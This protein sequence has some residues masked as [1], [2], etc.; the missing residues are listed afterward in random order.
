MGSFF[1]VYYM[2][3]K[4]CCFIVWCTSQASAQPKVPWQYAD[5]NTDGI[6]GI[7]LSQAYTLLKSKKSTTVIV[8]VIDSGIDTLQPDIAPILWK[9]PKEKPY[10][11][12]DDDGNGL[13]DDIIGWNY[14]G[15]PNMQNLAISVPEYYRTYYRFK[16]TYNPKKINKL[17]KP[18]LYQYQELK[19]AEA[20]L[21]A[22]YTEAL[23]R[24]DELLPYVTYL[25]LA[26]SSNK[27]QLGI[28]TYSKTELQQ[29]K[30]QSGL[31]KIYVAAWTNIF[32]NYEGNNTGYLSEIDTYLNAQQKLIDQKN[33]APLPY[34]DSLL[35]NDGYNITTTHYGNNNMQTHS[36]FHGTSV[37]GIIGAIRNN[38]IGVDGVANDVRIMM[39]RAILGN[40]EYDKDVALAIR[41]AVD[42]G[43]K[44]INMSFGKSVSP[45]KAWVDDAIQYALRKDVV[46]IHAAG[47][48]GTNNDIQ[49]NYPNA[50]TI[51]GKR[52]P[53]FIN[54]AASANNTKGNIIASF[55]NYGSKMVDVLAPGVDIECA[56]AGIAT[57]L[58]SGTSMASPMVAGIAALVR[59]YYPKL[60]AVQVVEVIL[61]SCTPI[62]GN[63][64]QPNTNKT[65]AA[66]TICNT[67]GVVNAAK[68]ITLANALY[69]KKNWR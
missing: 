12:T 33:N 13:V 19:R 3:K 35:L 58:A 32:T 65:V 8:A 22:N 56:I 48:D 23:Q 20:I 11:N 50:Y 31:S 40:D 41:Y 39:I 30:L 18:Q 25:K 45:D 27:K 63:V 7:S 16:N 21:N 37:S 61:K 59:S 17:T 26:D 69:T 24:I 43:A 15:A 54:V 2:I 1:Y 34:R 4:I 29:L 66:S 14:L 44:V 49:Y 46:V 42:N 68:A 9:N 62:T 47:N 52:L 36:G 60:T 55:T 10:N 64:A 51:A 57:R 38:G 6:Y 5:Y 28:S 67:G 53:N